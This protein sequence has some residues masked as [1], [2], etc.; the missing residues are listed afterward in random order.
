MSERLAAFVSG[1]DRIDRSDPDTLQD[2]FMN[3]VIENGGT[4][5]PPGSA[6]HC[7]FEISLHGIAAYGASEQIAIR[8]WRMAATVALV[9]AAGEEVEDDGFITAHPPCGTPRNH[10]EEIANALA[11]RDAV[12]PHAFNPMPFGIS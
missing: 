7:M 11:E 4:Y 10:A 6:E 5:D 8:N 3:E 1:L 12:D 9:N 2:A